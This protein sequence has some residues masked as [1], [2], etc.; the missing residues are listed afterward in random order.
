MFKKNFVFLF[1]LLLSSFFFAACSENTKTV[2]KPGDTIYMPSESQNIPVTGIRLSGNYIELGKEA[3]I[4]LYYKIGAV[5]EPA[6]A[7]NPTLIYKVSDENIATVDTNGLLTIKNFGEFYVDIHAEV[8]SSIYQKV[9]FSIIERKSTVVDMVNNP[10]SLYGYY[11]VSQYGINSKPSKNAP[12]NSNLLLSADKNRSGVIVTDLLIN[13]AIADIKLNSND[14]GSLSYGEISSNIFA[15]LNGEVL[16]NNVVIQLNLSNCPALADLGIIS[17]ESDVLYLSL[18][19]E[20]DVNTGTEAESTPVKVTEIQLEKSVEIDLK[21]NNWYVV[22]PVIMPANATDKRVTYTSSDNET[23]TVSEAGIVTAYKN[24]SVEITVSSKENPEIKS[25][26]QLNIKDTAV[27]VTDILFNEDNMTVVLDS[28]KKIEVTVLPDTATYKTVKFYSSDTSV[29]EIGEDTG[30]MTAKR[31]GVVDITA[32][33]DRGLFK[34]T[35]KVN[36]EVFT[37]PVTGILNVPAELYMA[38]GGTQ[39]ISAEVFPKYA[40]SQKIGYEVLDSN[41]N[42]TVSETGV[43]T[44]VSEGLATVRVYAVDYPAVEKT[45]KVQVRAESSEI[46]VAGI[47]INNLPANIYI[48][49]DKYTM[50]ASVEPENAN[51]NNIL[52][53]ESSDSAIAAVYSDG[54][55]SWEVVPTG[56]G[57]AD[58]TVYSKNGVKQTVTVK[59]DKVMNV[60]GYYSIDK[61]DYTY[62]ETVKTFT[63]ESDKLQGE[64]AINVDNSTIGLTGR[65]QFIPAEP[66]KTY[67]FNNW[68][69]LHINKS[70]ALDEADKYAKQTKDGLLSENVKV[71][72]GKTIEYTYVSEDGLKAVI[73]LTKVTDKTK[74]VEDRTIFLTPVDMVNDPHSVEGYY[75]MTWFYGNPYNQ[76]ST[77]YQPKFS[78]LPGDRPTTSDLGI[79]Y[80]QNGRGCLFGI[81]CMGGDGANG[82]VANYKGSFAVKVNG[83]GENAELSS[84][85]KVQMSGHE[86]VDVLWQ[87]Y[88]K[89]I[90]GTFTPVTFAQNKINEGKVIDK[91]IN[92]NL[93]SNSGNE[94]PKGASIAYTDLA[95]NIMQLE[96]QFWS[97]YQFMYKAEKVSDRYIDLPTDKYVSGDV[98]DRTPPAVPDLAVIKAIEALTG[99]VSDIE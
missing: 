64:F 8:D 88:L 32:V 75:T 83:T 12:S 61:V 28:P 67:M 99:P 41:T 59:V 54:N 22:S 30:I 25:V 1:I 86:D 20:Y 72:G 46:D 87:T 58:I 10:L 37:F 94:G 73:Y 50:T 5:A 14:M 42:V 48:D 93:V 24:G 18:V 39:Q 7:T 57:S 17:K 77:G 53:A 79:S 31:K 71:T 80:L 2:V 4:D 13:G 47:K 29:L 33:T 35:T 38:V 76:S 55:N 85:M 84:I 26:I 90:H 40:S 27:H 49:T 19:K 96:M 91:K 3:G 95:N 52:Y 82:S 6:E 97:T 9:D 51:I 34:K 56:K 70:I 78:H 11:K 15:Q 69:Y 89:Y 66:L 92:V 65:L 45:T 23:A 16:D 81:E 74:I 62:G 68:R 43:I 36:A 21:T 63:K 98:S 60:T 44:A